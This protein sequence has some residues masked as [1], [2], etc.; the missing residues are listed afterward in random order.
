MFSR[1]A[2]C[3][4]SSAHIVGPVDRLRAPIDTMSVLQTA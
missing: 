2:Y 1:F 3:S 4:L